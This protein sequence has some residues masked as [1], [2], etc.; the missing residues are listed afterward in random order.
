MKRLRALL[1]GFAV[2]SLA[3][4]P[5]SACRVGADHIL[6]E[7]RPQPTGLENA[8][9]IFGRFIRDP[10]VFEKERYPARPQG[11]RGRSEWFGPSLIGVARLEG[12]LELVPIYAR[13]SSCVLGWM[14]LSAPPHNRFAYMVGRWTELPD[15]SRAFQAGGEDGSTLPY[16]RVH[17]HY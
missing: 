1:A 6:F 17:W 2:I 8:E 7:E 11:R 12:S 4:T 3:V 10:Y 13:M 16:N 5:A 14:G 15:G 9:V